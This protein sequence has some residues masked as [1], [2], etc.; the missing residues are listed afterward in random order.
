MYVSWFSS[1][2]VKRQSHSYVTDG[3]NAAALRTDSLF[4]PPKTPPS[5]LTLG[6][7]LKGKTNV[8]IWLNVLHGLP[9][10]NPPYRAL[11][12]GSTST[13]ADDHTSILRRSTITNRPS[14]QDIPSARS[15]QI[16]SPMHFECVPWSL[17]IVPCDRIKICD[18]ASPVRPVGESIAHISRFYLV[19]HWIPTA[20]IGDLKH[21]RSPR[22]WR[23]CWRYPWPAWLHDY[24]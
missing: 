16:W 24:L 5:A 21:Q 4:K 20:V 1:T 12:P 7:L 11:L 9:R 19:K 3:L 18:D 6:F 10:N 8:I 2:I 13:F 15:I 22:L 14:Q 23:L 17:L